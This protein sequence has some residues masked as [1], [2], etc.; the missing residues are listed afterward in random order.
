M[1]GRKEN[2]YA[3]LDDNTSVRPQKRSLK[4]KLSAPFK[5]FKP[6]VKNPVGRFITDTFSNKDL[7]KKLGLTLLIVLIYR[8]L[9]AVPLPGIDMKVYQDYFGQVTASEAHYLF[10]LFTGGRLDSPSI[11][12]LGLA[13]YINASIIMQLLPYA[14]PRLKEMQKDGERGR[15]LINQITRFITVPLGFFYSIAYLLLISQRDFSNPNNDPTILADATHNPVYLI[16]HAVGSNWPTISKVLFMAII[17]TAGTVFLMWLSELITEKGIGNGSSMI[18]TAGILASLPTLLSKDLSQIDFSQIFQEIAKGNFVA[19]ANAQTL[20]IF[21]VIL[22]LILIIIGI[23]FIN[24]SVRKIEVQYAR[25]V[26]GDE[27]GKGSSLPI[28]FTM[29]GVLPVIF[30]FAILSVP[31]ILVPILKGA[32]QAGSGFYNFLTSLETSFLYA[33]QDQVVDSKDIVY[34]IVY[35]LLVLIFGVFYAF[36]VLNPEETA[37][38]LQKSGAFIPGI[39]PGKSTQSY[40]S[41]V[42]V[43]ISF[44]GSMM[45]AFIALTPI[46][47]S[48]LI[49]SSTGRNLAILSGI[50][51]TSILIIVSVLLDTMRQYKSIVST[52]SYEKYIN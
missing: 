40:I 7:M 45:L 3:A 26:R 16:A 2:N 41:A 29:T 38:N 52:R 9:S 12:G 33:T 5:I 27:I 31:Q 36:I 14:I 39:R 32:A 44:I 11:V 4:N 51:G 8:G 20:S 50:G 49:L 6:L 15:Q 30:T 10:V 19:L 18:I 35:F 46:L 42:L 13:A 47:A 24:E 22:G 23:I 1:F 34:A 28:K 25:R 48:D 37:E 43:R 21:G 17:L